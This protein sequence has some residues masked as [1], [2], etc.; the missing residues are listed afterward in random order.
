MAKF[1]WRYKGQGLRSQGIGEVICVDVGH[2]Q[3]CWG[4]G[5][6]ELRLPVNGAK[7]RGS[8]CS[9]L[10]RRGGLEVKRRSS[11]TEA[12]SPSHILALG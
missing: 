9:E 1:K 10:P 11:G 12:I 7:R 2:P 8:L 5:K 6:Q 4:G 3:E